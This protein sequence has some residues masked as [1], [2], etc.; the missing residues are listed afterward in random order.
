MSLGRSDLGVLGD[1][2][3]AVGLTDSGGEFQTDWLSNPGDYL[4]SVLADEH[5][6]NSLVTF[7][8]NVLG[9]SQQSRAADGTIWLPI[10]ERSAP[11]FHLFVVLDDQPADYVGI[12]VGVRIA[13]T[14]P[15]AS[16]EAHVPIFRAAKNGHSVESSILIG[17]A[18][19]V[20][21]VTAEVTVDGS[22]PVPGQ[23]HLGGIQ[24][25]VAVPTGG[26][27]PPTLSLALRQLQMPGATGA[28]DLTVSAGN[29]DELEHSILDLVLGLVRA[30]AAALPPGPL[31]ALAGLIGLRDG[32]GV[33][34][35]PFADFATE[36]VGALATWLEDVLRAPASRAGWVGQLASLLGGAVDGD[37]VGFA[38]GA[39]TLTVGVGAV[40]ASDGHTRLTPSIGIA[41]PVNAD[42][43]LRADADLCT[44]DLGTGAATAMPKLALQLWLG[45]RPDGGAVVLDQPGPP[46]VRVE[47]V[48]AGLAIDAAR[49]PTFV[50]A[51]DKVTI[52]THTHDTLDLSTPDAI[53]DAGGAVL[54]DI[55]DE[56]L[57]QL[58][59]AADAVKILLGFSKPPGHP[60]VSTIDFAGFLSD[61]LGAV[62]GYWQAVVHDHPSAIPAIVTTLRDLIADAAEAGG[63]VG[64]SGTVDDPW[65]VG[66]A[67][68][69]DLQAWIAGDRLSLA[70]AITLVVDSLGQACTRVE[71]KLQVTAIEIDLVAR[72][73][74]FLA[75]IAAGFNVRARGRPQAAFVT[76]QFSL[77]AD[78][79]GLM[80]VWS[81]SAGLAAQ[82]SA[83]NLAIDFGEGPL[84]VP[85]PTIGAN[86]HVAL[87]PEE[88]DKIE[89][90]LGGFALA[91]G[92]APLREVAGALG[93]IRTERSRGEP[94]RLR[95]AGL[96]TDAATAIAEW[97]AD[98]AIRDQALL[99]RA[100]SML[101]TLVSGSTDGI[102]GV[103]N[104]SGRPSDPWIVPMSRAASAAKLAV[105]IGP[106]GPLASV[107]TGPS[108]LQSWRPGLPG[109]G[110]ALLASVLQSGSL[111]ADDVAALIDGRPD[112][113]AGLDALVARWTGTDGRIV[114]PDAAPDGVVVHQVADVS[115]RDLPGAIDVEDLIGRV[116][117]TIVHVAVASSAALAWPDA[118]ADRLIDLTTSA[119]APDGF[120]P[121]AAATGDWFIALGG[122]AACRLTTGDTDGIAGQSARL[123][124]I[125]TGLGS[126]A[127]G[128]VVVADAESGHAVRRAADAVATVTDAILLG[129]PLGP[130]SFAVLDENPAADT[131]RLLARLLPPLSDD[132]TD[133]PDLGLGRGLV[134]GLTSLLSSDDPSR[135][136]QAPSPAPPAPRA[137][138]NMHAVFGVID[139][140]SVRR[141]LTAVVFGGLIARANARADIEFVEP[142]DLH[143]A[144]RLP[145]PAGTPALGDPIVDGYADFELADVTLDGLGAHLSTTRMLT[146]HAEFGRL[147]CWLVGG[148]DPSRAPGVIPDKELRRVSLDVSVPMGSTGDAS[149]AITLH[150]ARAY[151]VDRERWIVQPTGAVP[152]AGVDAAT[153]A[154]PE[155]R[156]LLSGL[157]DALTGP[158]AGPAK[159][160]A[161]ALEAIHILAP[162]GGSVAE[163]ID[164]LLHDPIAHLNSVI[165]TTTDRQALVTAI[166]ALFSGSGTTAD[167]AHFTAG[168]A[169]VDVDLSVRRVTIVTNVSPDAFGLVSWS[170]HLTLD[171]AAHTID[172][173]FTIGDTGATV[174]GGLDLHVSS[175]FAVV[176]RTYRPGL[177]TPELLPLW[178]SPD[179]AAIARAVARVMPAELLRVALESL[180]DLDADVRPILDAGLIAI[181]LLTD[182]AADGSRRVRL[183]LALI[184]DPAAWFGHDAVLGGAG[185]LVPAKL[186][187][188]VD[189]LKP[190]IGVPGDPGQWRLTNGITVVA[191][192]GTGGAAR[193]T[194]AI[195]SSQFAPIPAAAGRLDVGG[196]VG[197]SFPAGAPPR[198]TFDLFVGIDGAATPGRQAVHVAFAAGVQVFL[199][200]ATGAD[201]PIYPNAAGLAQLAQSAI[202]QAL[203]FVLDQ[204]AGL[205]GH[206]G[207]SGQVGTLVATLGDALGVRTG[208]HFS[209]PALQAWAADPAAAI[210][211]RLPAWTTIV[212]GDIVTA[213]GPLLPGGVGASV[214]GPAL[215]VHVGVVTILLT[216]SPLSI[217]VTG[218]V[219][220]VPAVSTIAFGVSLS[221][222]GLTALD[223][224]VGPA[225][226]DAGGVMIKP[227]FGVHAGSAPVGGARA[228]LSLGVGDHTR[229]G[230]RWKFGDRF[231]LVVVDASG[232]SDVESTDAAQVAVALLEA[233]LDIVASFVLSTRRI[234]GSAR[235]VRGRVDGARRAA[236][237]AAQR[238]GPDA[239]RR[240]P[241]RSG[242]A[243]HARAASRGERRAGGAVGGHRRP[244]RRTRR[245]RSRRRR[246]GGRRAPVARRARE[247]G[248]QRHHDLA[249]DRCALDPSARRS[250][251]ARRHRAGRHQ[252]R[253]GRGRD[254]V[255]T[256]RVGRR[257]RFAVRQERGPAAR[258]RGALAGID[259]AAPLRA[260]RRS[261]TGRRRRDSA[262]GSRLRR[263][264]RERRQSGRARRR[265]RQRQGI[266]RAPAEVQPGARGAEARAPTRCS[267]RCAR[268]IGSGPWW[269]AIQ[270]G[271]GPVYIEQVGFGVT[272]RAATAAAHLDCCS[273]ARV[274]ASGSPRRSTTSRSRSSSRRTPRSSTRAAGRSTSPASRSRSDLGGITL[275]GGLRKFGV[276]A[277]TVQYIGMLMAPL[278]GVRPARSS[279]ATARRRADGGE[280]A[281]FFAFGAVNGPIGGPP[282]FFVTGIG[283]GLGINRGLVFPTDLSQFD[284]SRS[285]RRSTRRAAESGPDGGARR[286]STTTSRSSRASSGSPPASRFNSFALVDGVAV[287]AI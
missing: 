236:R 205:A 106:A 15:T 155:V 25:Q 120:T 191:D 210:V 217:T 200:P 185:G 22:A 32:V 166:R 139:E 157:A 78:R 230:A 193:I 48:R 101:A 273:T 249:R 17:T 5:Q 84:A 53:A 114:P 238:R 33:P 52:G 285:S 176:L 98:L 41:L 59:T 215:Q 229:V 281:S 234:H 256:G 127:G 221:A 218:E 209:G 20:V 80:L 171:A 170:T 138:L 24:L 275:A 140:D 110:S 66:L 271:F 283:G 4:S 212:V 263:R 178:P 69:V 189:A 142:T 92:V 201:I 282:A 154:L 208:G 143:V 119:I 240:E 269:L 16:I 111:V 61:P 18:D 168:P 3:G 233:V 28:R 102:E 11:D 14:D 260:S 152:P 2:A 60:E 121:P 130:V 187:A 257:R 21:T 203:P 231:D 196:S 214:V 270:K 245:R 90:L 253:A 74:T 85:I 199:R 207:V 169:T 145:L 280:F 93:W 64:G 118:P 51:A 30:Q 259:R 70:P 103:L 204:L 75:G 251:A 115:W 264:R 179:A 177:T 244:R 86:G 184:Q 94:A 131:L 54:G 162:A 8:D 47:T 278:R 224:E 192:T 57:G 213:V 91:T 65:R 122:R 258:R 141:A 202:T 81:P 27:T 181:G 173:D 272:V 46:A 225:A 72:S 43:V 13:A 151:G 107:G 252:C 237:R 39:A 223:V 265:E 277:D 183:P 7:V 34:P 194:L 247:A 279:A 134:T 55:A 284:R 56:V 113:A 73:V 266:D 10:V 50:L 12:G 227:F 76:S 89:R 126:V 158:P 29:A 246:E 62:A 79:V 63:A 124:R 44:L 190:F 149:A 232:V 165:T 250:A 160:V 117:D 287:I 104:G 182:P 45:H 261:A 206:A 82:F 68:P 262:L 133:N 109:F 243:A 26:G 97:I 180:R 197:L 137:G 132:F 164:H 135:E 276:G 226:I 99:R 159:A 242:A 58:G 105:W 163:A 88:W 174:A 254:H 35:L 286:S 112:I 87:A 83:P 148:P 241:V 42:I 156:I 255:R 125:I 147:N 150:E 274:A 268:A 100:L 108:P 31:T 95:L 129:T 77:T 267:S 38:L 71:S 9:G 216:P 116:P 211:A 37:Q 186:I 239:A 40:T 198:P 175:P 222:A 67:G 228:E 1:L 248:R 96:V 36:G 161:D 123:Q 6:R 153:P 235:Q 136:L 144:I 49:K 220:G 188:V 23:A 219:H 19:A 146:V 167:Q 172:G 195:D 128:L